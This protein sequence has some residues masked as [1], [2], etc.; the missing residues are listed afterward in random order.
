MF[1]VCTEVIGDVA[2]VQCEGRLVHSEAAFQLR[3]A[4]MAL[5]NSRVIAVDLSGVG[6]IEG[7]S[8]GMLAY[9]E[10]W[11]HD[12]DIKLKLFN[13]RH[14]VSESLDRAWMPTLEIASADEIIALL[15]GAETRGSQNAWDGGHS[16][17]GNAVV[18]L[19]RPHSN[20]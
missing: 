13:P 10:R 12:H 6:A 7:G 5:R 14:S 9:L 18:D 17:V 11:A 1:S 16:Q 15:D 2:V 4:V 3:D 8:L 19:R 20:L